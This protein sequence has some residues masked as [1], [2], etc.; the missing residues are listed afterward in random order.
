MGG[1]SGAGVGGVEG[2]EA[3]SSSDRK[4]RHETSIK[5]GPPRKQH[6][7][8]RSPETPIA[9]VSSGNS[10]STGGTTATM[11]SGSSSTSRR[12]ERHGS[13]GRTVTSPTSKKG[14][15]HHRS[16][17]GASSTSSK[18][19]EAGGG[20]ATTAGHESNDE[21]DSLAATSMTSLTAVASAGDAM[22]PAESVRKKLDWASVSSYTRKASTKLEKRPTTALERFTP[23]A[24]F[25]RIGV[26]P[27]L[28][29]KEYFDTISSHVSRHL[30]KA[31]QQK[32]V[33]DQGG[34]SNV[35]P[36]SLL[37]SPFEGQQF[38]SSCVSR[39]KDQLEGE[40]MVVDNIG[41]CRRA[42]TASADYTIR[43]KLKKSNQV[44]NWVIELV[45]FMAICVSFVSLDQVTCG[46][47]TS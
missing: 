8:S 20:S 43:R 35:L 15:H 25:A 17:K 38:A 11:G 22:T 4:R 46:S 45:V 31:Y 27:S 9:G 16:S 26:S 2:A 36:K 41:P 24:V 5:E 21:N 39:I 19:T 33:G 12:H 3:R 30:R 47:M 14:E 13:S 28:A 32:T 23:G 34:G 37:D 10:A 18:K 40:R 6:L 29:G 1:A 7:R 44:S 42:L